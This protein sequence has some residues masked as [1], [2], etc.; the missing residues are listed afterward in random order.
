MDELKSMLNQGSLAN[1]D[2]WVNV[3]VL[4]SFTEL[5][6]SGWAYTFIYSDFSVVKLLGGF[7]RPYKPN[8]RFTAYVSCILCFL[9][10]FQD[11]LDISLST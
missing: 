2:V 9:D 4:D 1:K 6:R 11:Y 10:L 3:T 5:V 7:V 8:M